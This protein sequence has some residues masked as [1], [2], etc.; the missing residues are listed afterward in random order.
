MI[1]HGNE[2]ESSNPPDL[3]RLLGEISRLVTQ[4]SEE[5]FPD[6][7]DR[8]L[9]GVRA[10]SGLSQGRIALFDYVFDE[11]HVLEVDRNATYPAIR[12]RISDGLQSDLLG[13]ELPLA[14]TDKPIRLEI[15]VSQ[16]VIAG[17]RKLGE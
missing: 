3:L 4:V 2:L 6:I 15:L 16:P 12:R 5:N 17:S 14:D 8:I 11:F 7:I 13:R 9:E 10:V 1:T